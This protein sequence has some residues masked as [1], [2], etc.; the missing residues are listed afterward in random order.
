V[1]TSI[2]TEEATRDHRDS[3]SAIWE[4][5]CSVTAVGAIGELFLNWLGAYLTFFGEPVVIDEAQVRRYW[6]VLGVLVV[7]VAGSFVA[8][9]RRKAGGAWPW[10]LLVAAA[11]AAA[12]LLCAVTQTGTPHDDPAPPPAQHT[13]PLCYSG[14]DNTGCPGG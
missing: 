5:L 9:A 13:G 11:G 7:S 3:R 1:P 10:H 12:A 6:I 4:A 14:G 8:A 2:T